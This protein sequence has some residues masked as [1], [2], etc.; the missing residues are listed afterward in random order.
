MKQAQ[1]SWLSPKGQGKVAPEFTAVLFEEI[2]IL[3]IKSPKPGKT[4]AKCS[5]HP[6]TNVA[7]VALLQ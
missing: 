6:K 4:I 7:T 5:K 3:W 1:L 2:G